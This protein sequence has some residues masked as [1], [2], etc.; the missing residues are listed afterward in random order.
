M[1]VFPY[2][3]VGDRLFLLFEGSSDSLVIQVV[4]DA[5]RGKTTKLQIDHDVMARF[6]FL[7]N[8]YGPTV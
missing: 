1:G 3:S 7:L 2:A 4:L 5:Q 6:R 8:V